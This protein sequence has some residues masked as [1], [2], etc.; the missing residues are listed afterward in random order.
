MKKSFIFLLILIINFLF[1]NPIL[2]GNIL[3]ITNLIIQDKMVNLNSIFNIPVEIKDVKDLYGIGF[4]I[5]YD[6]T[7]LEFINVY[8]G[9]FL[10]SDNQTTLFLKNI[11]E[12]NATI[13]IG[14]SRVGKVNGISGNG[15]IL[16]IEFKAI[17]IG[18]TSLNLFDIILKDSNLNKIEY[19]LKLGKINIQ[20][21]DNEPPKINV[22]IPNEVYSSTYLIS[23]TI[24][25]E[26]SG[27]KILKINGKQI[28]LLINGSFNC[29]INLNKGINLIE[30]EAEDYIG[31]KIN[32]SYLIYYKELKEKTIIK[33]QINNKIA[34]I[35]DQVLELDVAPT[36]LP[37][38][39]TVIPLR[40]IGESFG[41]NIEWENKTKTI[42]LS[43]DSI[44]S[45]NNIIVMKDTQIINLN[46]ILNQCNDNIL[47]LNEI[48]IDKD[49]KIKELEIYINSLPNIDELQKKINEK[50]KKIEELSTKINQLEIEL[51]NCKKG[52]QDI[53]P[54]QI[55]IYE[56]INN[57]TVKDN[58]I[59]I[60]GCVR[61]NNK[62]DYLKIYSKNIIFDQC[63]AFEDYVDL[64]EGKNNIIIEA[65]DIA[66]NIKKESL[67]IYYEKP[68]DWELSNEQILKAIEWGKIN[69]N[70][71][72]NFIIPF[73]IGDLTKY[74]TNLIINTPYFWIAFES[75]T[76]AEK[77]QDYTLE[78]AKKTLALFCDKL[79][80]MTQVYGDKIDFA[81]DYHAVIEID[82]KYIQPVE[83]KNTNL[84]DMTSKWPYSP[85][86][87]ALNSY[88][89][90]NKDVPRKGKIKFILIR[91]PEQ[92]EEKFEIDL[93]KIP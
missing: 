24:N 81:K 41:A 1:T 57:I 69:K 10:K 65:K 68:K 71:F 59:K 6:N 62:L 7:K 86:Y 91:Y 35:N 51:E 87:F 28:P 85:A 60:K 37:P 33:M 72:E 43:M 78:D 5:K 32:K 67:F 14:I 53:E 54:P 39:R 55:F 27:V 84:A 63:G 16:Y 38:G 29:V 2:L 42:T 13:Q 83:I 45:L 52:N 50:D 3:P 30:I 77:Y 79:I 26:I 90:M 9:E 80:I 4:N 11:D 18:S 64:V 70:K 66:G 23:G 75:K 49:K 8:E 21:P 89:F 12:K 76:K 74:T 46:N 22:S 15:I 17:E 73:L 36:I 19:L 31:N 34:Y 56:P 58:R 47:A 25:D 20:L 82:G 88:T 61:D 44:N 92:K 93:S 40:F 48:I